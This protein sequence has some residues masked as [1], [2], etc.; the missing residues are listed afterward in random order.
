LGLEWPVK[1]KF[2]ALFR[3][4]EKCFVKKDMKRG[5]MGMMLQ[6]TAWRFE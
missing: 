5:W 4:G 3:V 6:E 1:K 2:A